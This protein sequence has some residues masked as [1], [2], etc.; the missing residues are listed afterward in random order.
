[1]SRL[2]GSHLTE[3]LMNRLGGVEVGVHEGKIIPI[4]T[5]DERGWPHP[6]L[7]S[8]YEVRARDASTLDL[9]LWKESSTAN[10][11]RRTGVLT[12]MITDEGVNYYLKGTVQL[13]EVEMAGA[14][15]V[16]RF[17]MNV[18][19]VLEDQEPNAVITTGLTYRRLNKR[20][21]NDFAVKVFNL[22][23]EEKH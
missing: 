23:C 2:V 8:Y 20:D 9:A 6:A 22:L 15:Q 7:L 4:F 1:M 18:E 19:Q 17:R 13:L 10:N 14:P 3:A 21:S 12:V 11:L 5:L 16:S